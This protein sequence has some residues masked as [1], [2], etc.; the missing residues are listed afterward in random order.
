MKSIVIASTIAAVVAFAAPMAQAK[1]CLKGAAV[2][3]VA[4]H[5]AGKALAQPQ[6]RGVGQHAAGPA[7]HVVLAH[8]CAG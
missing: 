1:G 2:G 3:G 4:G 6:P 8:G 5:V 7:E